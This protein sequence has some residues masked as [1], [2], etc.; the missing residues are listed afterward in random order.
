[1]TAE[2]ND[3]IR[4]LLSELDEIA[5]N[6]S[7]YEFGLPMYVP[8]EEHDMTLAVLSFLDEYRKMLVK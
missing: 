7:P 6:Y 3:K 5:R 8:D 2:L 1:M 4:D